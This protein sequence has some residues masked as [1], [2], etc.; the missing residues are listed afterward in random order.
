MLR[1]IELLIGT[2]TYRPYVFVFFAFYLFLAVTRLGYYVTEPAG[3][4]SWVYTLKGG[5][6]FA[7]P[8]RE[9]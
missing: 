3:H 9:P 6:R 7:R 5:H 1:V 2:V 8:Q 4:E